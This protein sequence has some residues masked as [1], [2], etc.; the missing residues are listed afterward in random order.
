MLLSVDPM[1]L[2]RTSILGGIWDNSIEVLVPVQVLLGDG[3]PEVRR[4]VA[5]DL[6]EPGHLVSEQAVPQKN[7][8]MVKRSRCKAQGGN[9]AGSKVLEDK[10]AKLYW[11][12]NELV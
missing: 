8:K 2:Q 11:K 5:P 1:R 12:A 7:G 9:I 3:G 10:M 6:P 4:L